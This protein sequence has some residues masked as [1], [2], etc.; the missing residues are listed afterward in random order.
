MSTA[1][2][3]LRRDGMTVREVAKAMRISPMRVRQL[4]AR[5]LEKLRASGI[6]YDYARDL[7]AVGDGA[8]EGANR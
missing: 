8:T 2:D 4:E 6:L 7:F 5:A 3:W 1:H